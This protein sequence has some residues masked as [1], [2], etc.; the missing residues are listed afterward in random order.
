MSISADIAAFVAR[1]D[2]AIDSAMQGPVL[3]GAKKQILFLRV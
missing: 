3:D 2:S 1:L